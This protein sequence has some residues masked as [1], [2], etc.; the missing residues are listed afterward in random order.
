MCHKGSHL[1]YT[2]TARVNCVSCTQAM[3]LLGYKE[4]QAPRLQSLLGL[5]SLLSLTSITLGSVE[6]SHSALG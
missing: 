4:A 5:S 3:S 2:A 6:N 1:R